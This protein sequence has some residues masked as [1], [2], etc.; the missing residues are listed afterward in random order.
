M[1]V[2]SVRG[3][4]KRSSLSTALIITRRELR[5]SLRDW[6]IIIPIL[7]L[8]L[9]FPFL[10]DFTATAARNFVLRYG[11]ANAIIAERL[12]PFLLM[13]VGFFPISFSLVIALET[14]VGEKER[15]SLEPLLSMPISDGELYLGK[16]LAALLLPLSASYLGIAVYLTGLHLTLDWLPEVALLIQVV[17]LT[18]VEALVMVS[19]AVV[20]SSQTTSVRAANLLASFIIIPTALLV[21]VESVLM[22]WGEYGVIWWIILG[23]VVVDLILV[24]M[25]VRTFNRE[26]ILSKEMDDLNL[27]TIWRDFWG[28]F[29]RPPDLAT[30]RDHARSSR[31]DLLR[32]YAHDIPTLIKAAWLPLVLVLIAL[33]G[34]GILGGYYAT[35]YPFPGGILQ[36]D[37]LP[38][39]A[40][41][42]LPSVDFLPHFSTAGIFFNNVRAITLAAVLGIFSFGALAL[43]LLMIPLA[44]VGFFAV[45]VSLLGYNPWIFVAAFLLPHGIIELPA[46]IIGT[47]FALRIGAALV[48]PPAGLDVGQGFLLVLANFLKVFLFLVVPMLL[49]AAFIEANITPQIVLALYSGR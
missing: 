31:F 28:Y 14:F 47:A 19:G 6:R 26:E 44:L 29:L 18:T 20:V 40:F 10:M 33:T 25:G 38:T 5:D 43:I 8:T 21:Q 12:N 35:R 46:A 48:S 39:N 22:F 36:L 41:E 37:A 17:L 27:K 4:L 45:E 16:M 1:A 9:I 24:R 7:I 30:Q 32:I 49:I 11:G 23:L 13:I 2:A 42:S 34:G 15:N 3:T